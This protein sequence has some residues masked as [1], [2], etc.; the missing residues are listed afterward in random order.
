M[1]GS[2]LFFVSFPLF[3]IVVCHHNFNSALKLEIS[4]SEDLSTVLISYD[5]KS[6]ICH[7]ARYHGQFVKFSSFAVF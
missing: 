7:L 3:V 6:L 5:F 1:S 2:S 4:Q